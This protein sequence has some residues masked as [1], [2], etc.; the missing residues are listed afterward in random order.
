MAVP[1]KEINGVLFHTEILK[2]AGKTNIFSDGFGCKLQPETKL[3]LDDWLDK[4]RQ[5]IRELLKKYGVLTISD[6]VINNNNVTRWNRLGTESGHTTMPW[7][8]DGYEGKSAVVL[9]QDH[10]DIPRQQ[11][12]LV[13]PTSIVFSR[14]QSA[15]L[16]DESICPVEK[17]AKLEKIFQG[18]SHGMVKSFEDIY[19]AFSNSQSGLRS[20]IRDLLD[21]T[22]RDCDKWIYR[23]YW[24]SNSTVIMDTAHYSGNHG[25]YSNV[26][27]ARVVPEGEA[28]EGTQP[29]RSFL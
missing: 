12:T 6:V 25:I 9:F 13:A 1:L 20:V 7:H 5:R 29:W 2:P 28:I 22:L 24:T 23:H 3:V 10:D 8:S 11:P 15:F 16:E 19:R 14:M 21:I 17:R 26:V 4:D 18:P 27:H